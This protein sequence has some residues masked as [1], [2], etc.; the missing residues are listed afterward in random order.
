MLW[1][2]DAGSSSLP[3]RTRSALI[4]PESGRFFCPFRGMPG[5]P[6]E[7]YAAGGK[8]AAQSYPGRTPR[9]LAGPAPE[10]IQTAGW[11]RACR[12]EDSRA[13]TRSPADP[14]SGQRI[15]AGAGPRRWTIPEEGRPGPHSRSFR[16]ETRGRAYR[17]KGRSRG[18]GREVEICGNCLYFRRPPGRNRGNFTEK[19][20]NTTGQWRFP[21]I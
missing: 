11:K 5:A 13:V 21:V 8:T 7:G 12:K 10:A 2:H 19:P 20:E 9:G 16:R 14:P 6:G 17:R 3:T 4:L 15:P 18:G 1:E